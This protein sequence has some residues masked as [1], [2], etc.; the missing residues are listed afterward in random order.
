MRTE[1][2]ETLAKELLAVWSM[3]DW[4]VIFHDEE[5]PTGRCFVKSQTISISKHV[6]DAEVRDTILHEI[7]HA[8]APD[9]PDHNRIWR[10]TA[11]QVGANPGGPI[12]PKLYQGIDLDAQPPEVREAIEELIVDNISKAQL[13]SRSPGR[14]PNQIR[15]S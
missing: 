5:D 7:A 9:E 11:R 15:L 4:R 2:I 1:D 14:A 3:D 13:L 6:S 8:L 10:D 12:M